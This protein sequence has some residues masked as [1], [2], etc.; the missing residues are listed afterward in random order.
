[1]IFCKVDYIK[2]NGQKFPIAFN[3]KALKLGAME[4]KTSMNQVFELMQKGNLAAAADLIPYFWHALEVGHEVV[5]KEV[6]FERA[7]LERMDFETLGLFTEAFVNAA[8]K[9]DIK[10]KKHLATVKKNK[11]EN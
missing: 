11:G 4:T 3:L 5:Q 2:L 7:A 9:M 1:M 10:E 6:P 8:A